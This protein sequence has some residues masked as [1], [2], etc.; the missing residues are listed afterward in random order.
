MGSNNFARCLTNRGLTHLVVLRDSSGENKWRQKWGNLPSVEIDLAEPVYKLVASTNG[1]QI[2]DLYKVAQFRDKSSCETPPLLSFEWSGVRPTLLPTWSIDKLVYEDGP[3]VGWV[4]GNES[5]SIRIKS[6]YG[7]I[8][9]LSLSLVP[10]FG[11]YASTQIVV[12]QVNG[13]GKSV[14]LNPGS[15]TTVTLQVSSND[16]VSFRSIMP[17]ITPSRVIVNNTDTRSLC[18]GITKIHYNIGK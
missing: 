5:P 7:G 8:Y 9:D 16:L 10:A 17:C 12:F 15:E 6:N 14:V 18:F 3:D 11:Q 1:N 13:V 2:Y 4:F